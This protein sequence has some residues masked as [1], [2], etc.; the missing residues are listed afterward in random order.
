M[1]PGTVRLFPYVL[2]GLG[3]VIQYGIRPEIPLTVLQVRP[4]TVL[5]S[6][7]LKT[8]THQNTALG[9]R[10]SKSFPTST[11]Q[12]LPSRATAQ[13]Q[14]PAAQRSCSYSKEI[15]GFAH[16]SGLWEIRRPLRGWHIRLWSPR[17][18]PNVFVPLIPVP[19][20]SPYHR[21]G[22]LNFSCLTNVSSP[23][24]P[25]LA[26]AISLSSHLPGAVPVHPTTPR[27]IQK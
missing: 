8:V 13:E 2:A 7:R 26:P 18:P 1:S 17:F 9:R 6:D 19:P 16:T 15:C 27:R 12:A 5:D 11:D 3:V 22:S 4:F 24:S 14:C 20:S 23:V 25:P 10:L 21:P